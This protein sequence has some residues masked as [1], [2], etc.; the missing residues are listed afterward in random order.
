MNV[1]LNVRSVKTSRTLCRLCVIYCACH[2]IDDL[3]LLNLKRNI[4]M[5]DEDTTHLYAFSKA[6][7]FEPALEGYGD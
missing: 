7:I 5:L 3:V 1:V 6:S 4:P 2:L